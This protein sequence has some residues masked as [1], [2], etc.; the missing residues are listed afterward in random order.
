MSAWVACATVAVTSLPVLAVTPGDV[1]ITEIMYN[2]AS[3]EESPVITE[4]VEICNTSPGP[5]DLTNWYVADED[6]R[7]GDFEAFSLPAGGIAV[8]IPRGSGTK[9][10]CKTDFTA[11]WGI[12]GSKLVQVTAQNDR[13]GNRPA[14]SAQGLV[15]GS[16]LANGATNNGDPSDDLVNTPFGA[17]SC[18]YGQAACDTSSGL[19]N[20]VILL[21]DSSHQVIDQVN[22]AAGFGWPSSSNGRSIYL[23][24]HSLNATANDSGSNWSLSSAGTD[25]A[26]G[27]M[28]TAI[29]DGE[30]TGSPGEIQGVTTG[31]QA[32]FTATQSTFTTVGG[33][34]DITL[35]ATDDGV[36]PLS[37]IIDA[38]PDEGTLT[39]V[40]NG[41]VVIGAAPYTLPANSAVVRYTNNSIC[42]DDSFTF[43]AS[44][45]DL[46]SEAGTVRI[47]IQCGQVII[48]EI[49]Y[50][51]AS[52]ENNPA[53]SEWIEIYNASGTAINLT[54]WYLRDVS[55]RSGDFPS[56]TLARGEVAVVIPHGSDTQVVTLTDFTAAWG[57]PATNLIQPT[58]ANDA[59]NGALVGG[60][61]GNNPA[62]GEFVQIVDSTGR[63]H[64][65]AD[66]DNS[67]PWPSSNGMSS[68]YITPGNYDAGSNDEP[69]AWA[70]SI[71]CTDGAQD[72]VLTRIFNGMPDYGSP[73]W[74]Q[75]I[76]F[77]NRPPSGQVRSYGV[78]K[79]HSQLIKLAV[80]DD[81]VAGPTYVTI[82]A[83]PT[84][85]LLRD[86]NNGGEVI[87]AGDLPYRLGGEAGTSSAVVYTPMQDYVSTPVLSP[88]G[89][90]NNDAF[91]YRVT[92]G[93]GLTQNTPTTAIVVVQ[94]G[95]LVITEI[96]YDPSD[97]PTTMD[98]NADNDWE[99]LEVTN[100]SD[101][102]VFLD[103][104]VD[105]NL[106][107]AQQWNLYGTAVPAHST[108]V[109]LASENFSRTI[110]EFLAE[111]SCAGVTSGELILIDLANGALKPGFD[112]GGDTLYLLSDDGFGGYV[113][114]DRV[115]YDNG[116]G[117]WPRSSNSASIYLKAGTFNA[118]D[119]EDPANWRLSVPGVAEACATPD[120]VENPGDPQYADSDVGS[121]GVLATPPV[122]CDAPPAIVSAVSRKVH[123][124]RGAFDI[125]ILPGTSTEPR[126]GGSTQV[127]VV[128]DRLVAAA[129]GSL[130][131]GSE[132]VVSS[133]IVAT[134]AI[135]GDTLTINMSGA[136][137]LS[138]LRVTL[139]GIACDDPSPARPSGVMAPARLQVR[140]IYADVNNDGQV[141]SGD[142]TQVKAVSG[143]AANSANF[144]RDVN[145]DGQVA[146]GD[147]TVTKSRSGNQAEACQ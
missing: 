75:G 19:D 53:I 22:Y 13:S 146:S 2:P 114:Q 139:S 128:F 59:T 99:W 92:D 87:D 119:N 101:S 81:G 66:Y 65:V 26:R 116:A 27:N 70:L 90:T 112:N 52:T 9:L 80:C 113:L 40:N 130:N 129:D 111:W 103:S 136:T 38:L 135:T 127:V 68:I 33:S 96:M 48:T 102:T 30:D 143:Q 60:N 141:A 35:T 77:G 29:F 118:A 122:G 6:G 74:L 140:Q 41:N 55:A 64:D 14:N 84:F 7:S 45:G 98:S 104:L 123:G 120:A 91:E 94:E 86:P 72:N 17:P 8:I 78:I 51:P 134:A 61:L 132:V 11:A 82:L 3:N 106:N 76:S 108:R 110:H 18:P 95:A 93:E 88:D 126:I 42:G 121:P 12:A 131:V 138:C 97:R 1:I 58:A 4:W 10:L 125:D 21:V 67:F 117:G 144:R 20:E 47:L 142:I 115:R 15:V 16:N 124:E 44:D 71:P 62:G 73:G 23:L 32:P 107:G 109:M 25:R 34:V 39:D 54:G 83:L 31:N 43:K 69:A 5:I 63:V 147:I 24:L 46:T 105:V 56:F 36:G 49:M 145:A 137:N 50:N 57:V 85:G 79:N 133:G 89:G 28:I 100:I 37:F